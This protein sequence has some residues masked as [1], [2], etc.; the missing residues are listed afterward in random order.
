MIAILSYI[1][2]FSTTICSQDLVDD[3]SASA[4]EFPVNNRTEN[5]I[6]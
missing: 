3:F 4:Q 6:Y 1:R 5:N 2:K